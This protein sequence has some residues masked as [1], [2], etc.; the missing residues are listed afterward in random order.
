MTSLLFDM[1]LPRRA[2]SDLRDRGWDVQHVG[3]LHLSTASDAAI[4]DRAR[5]EGRVVVTL[6][7]DF[8]ALLSHSGASS[9][10]VIFIRIQRFP[11]AEAVQ[12]L[13]Q[14]VPAVE[15]DLRAGAIVSVSEGGARV[16]P[17]PLP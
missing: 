6:D 17:L 1:G 4:L 14:L 15:D 13:E 3:E 2:A 10:S 5:A 9:P 12:L 7:S 16:R 11:R 8:S